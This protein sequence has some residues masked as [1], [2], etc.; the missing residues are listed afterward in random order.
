M[1]VLLVWFFVFVVGFSLLVFFLIK[2]KLVYLESR[3]LNKILNKIKET[4]QAQINF[5]CMYFLLF[6]LALQYKG[7]INKGQCFS[8][9]EIS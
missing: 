5:C 6:I 7:Q 8:V 3:E 2:P 4:P 1:E 9:L